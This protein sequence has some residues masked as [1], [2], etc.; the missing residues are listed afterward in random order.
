MRALGSS[1]SNLSL[2]HRLSLLTAS[3]LLGIILPTTAAAYCGVKQSALAVGREQLL[4]LTQPLVNLPQQSTTNLLSPISKVTNEPAVIV[5]FP[6]DSSVLQQFGSAQ[7]PNGSQVELWS[8]KKSLALSPPEDSSAAAVA[9]LTSE[10]EDCATDGFSAGLD[11]HGQIHC[12]LS[13][14][15]RSKR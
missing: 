8:V 5:F 12:C 4:N 13:G 10:F 7:N 6:S 9:V 3:L 1:L 11:R 2:K 14:R 15:S